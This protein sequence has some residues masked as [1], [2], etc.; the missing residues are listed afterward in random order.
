MACTYLGSGSISSPEFRLKFREAVSEPIASTATAAQVRQALESLDTIGV[1]EVRYSPGNSQ[2]CV[3]APGNV[4]TFSFKSENGDLPPLTVEGD[5]A[6]FV[7]GQDLTFSGGLE[8]VE[9]EKGTT[10]NDE[11]SGRGRCNH[12]TGNCDCFLGFGNSDGSGGPGDRDDCG[13]REPYIP[14]DRPWGA[15]SAHGRY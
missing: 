14:V 13:Y 11:C 1:I 9:A 6:G 7:Q 12:N 15:A 8:A 10:E 5:G 2:A 3:G 4:I